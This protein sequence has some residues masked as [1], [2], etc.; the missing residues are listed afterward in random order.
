LPGD[1]ILQLIDRKSI[2]SKALV[3]LPAYLTFNNYYKFLK[4]SAGWSEKQLQEYQLRELSRLLRHAYD[5]VPYYRRVFDKL[6]LKP[7]DIQSFDDLR[8]LPLLTKEI[9]RD[10]YVD[11]KAKN[12]PERRL[13]YVSSGGTT[14]ERMKFCYEKSV[15]R[16]I[17]WAFIKNLWDTVGYRFT[18]KCAILRGYDVKPAHKGVYW[19]KTLFG[20]WLILSSGYLSDEHMEAYINKIRKFKPKYIQAYPSSITIL[21]R[22]MKEHETKPFSSIKAVILSSESIYPGQRELI[23]DVFKCKTYAFYGQTERVI[24]AGECEENSCYH[25]SPEYGILEL[26]RPDGTPVRQE[27]ESGVM[28][29]TSLTSFAMPLI[30]YV[31]NDVGIYTEQ[32]CECGR[33]HQLLKGIQGRTQDY[34]ITS[35]NKAIPF[36]MICISVRS[37]SLEKARQYQYSQENAGELLLNIVRKDGFTEKDSESIRKEICEKFGDSI[38]ITV[39]NVDQIQRTPSGKQRMLVQKLP[40]GFMNIGPNVPADSYTNMAIDENGIRQKS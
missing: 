16:A 35:D 11:F 14:G 30:R 34:V 9:I 10:N 40:I 23:E 24:L 28:V 5:N 22:Y 27:G 6:G 17:E 33:E 12:Y 1:I 19:E 29:G 2:T 36:T 38:K 31:T 32:L 39:S 25:V 37:S 15:S 3:I 13:E 26:L 21:A 18:D 20:R 8:K 4:K 7:D